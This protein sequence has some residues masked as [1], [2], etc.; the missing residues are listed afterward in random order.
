MVT[1]ALIYENLGKLDEALNSWRDLRTEEGCVKTVGILRKRE[2]TDKK[3]VWNYMDWVLQMN[4]E[5]GLSLF[6]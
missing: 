4:P 2:I 3:L 5:V 1:M 6:I